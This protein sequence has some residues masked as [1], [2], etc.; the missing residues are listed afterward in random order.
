MLGHASVTASVLVI[1]GASPM[2]GQLVD[3][4]VRNAMSAAPVTLARHAT[5]LGIDNHV[6]RAGGIGWA[7]M[8]D[9]P[10]LPNNSP[11]CVDATWIDFVDALMDKRPPAVARVGVGYMLQDDMPVSNVDPFATRPTEHNQWVENSGPH[12]MIIVPDAK[13]LNGFPTDPKNGGP[14]VMWKGT[15]YEHLMIP[16]ARRQP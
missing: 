2:P 8:P 5:I 10:A 12:I 4:L 11:M 16:T 14:W 15:P 13:H 6:V 1:L 7:C 3:S 9:N